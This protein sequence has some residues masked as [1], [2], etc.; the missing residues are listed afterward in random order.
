MFLISMTEKLIGEQVFMRETPQIFCIQVIDR[1]I[2]VQSLV[3]LR[4]MGGA[5]DQEKEEDKV[6][7]HLR[8]RH[9]ILFL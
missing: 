3:S 4:A 1:V 8:A 2:I 9:F 6:P 5:T 7:E